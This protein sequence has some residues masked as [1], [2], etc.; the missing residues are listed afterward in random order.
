M[1]AKL[2]VGVVKQVAKEDESGVI[3][4]TTKKAIPYRSAKGRGRER[5]QLTCAV[6]SARSGESQFERSR[7]V[8]VAIR[9]PKKTRLRPLIG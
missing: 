5:R 7:I 9:R 2:R 6:A 1:Q 3:K 4:K 8:G